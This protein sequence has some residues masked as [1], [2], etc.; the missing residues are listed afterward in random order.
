MKSEVIYYAGGFRHI[1]QLCITACEQF[2]LS[3]LS[4]HKFVHVTTHQKKEPKSKAVFSRSVC[5]PPHP[6]AQHN[7][8]R[9]GYPQVETL[10][11]RGSVPGL[12]I[13]PWTVNTAHAHAHTPQHTRSPSGH[14]FRAIVCVLTLALARKGLSNEKPL[15]SRSSRVHGYWP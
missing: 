13:L 10:T 4:R 3:T 8:W 14:P 15:I 2:E 11:C 9:V 7:S 5:P 6:Q 12:P 1:I